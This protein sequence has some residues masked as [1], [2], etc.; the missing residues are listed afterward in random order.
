[1]LLLLACVDSTPKSETAPEETAT[2]PPPDNAVGSTDTG[3]EPDTWYPDA[4]QDGYGDRD[5]PIEACV[6]PEGAVTNANDCN[7]ADPEIHRWGQDLCDGSTDEDCDGTVDEDNTPGC[8]DRYADEDGDGVGGDDATCVCDPS[9]HPELADTGDCDDEDPLHASDC[10]SFLHDISEAT[11]TW[12]GSAELTRFYG[13]VIGDGTVTLMLEDALVPVSPGG[14]L[15]TGRTAWINGSNTAFRGLGD[16]DGD[17]VSELLAES[18]ISS[19]SW[20]DGCYCDVTEHHVTE[21]VIAAPMSGEQTTSAGTIFDLD[22]NVSAT[23]GFVGDIDGDGL[24][25]IGSVTDDGVGHTVFA[26]L[27]DEFERVYTGCPY[28]PAVA[29]GDLDGDGYNDVAVDGCIALGPFETFGY[30]ADNGV[31]W[32]IDLALAGDRDEDGYPELIDHDGLA[33]YELGYDVAGFDGTPIVSA[34]ASSTLSAVAVA[35]DEGPE[36]DLVVGQ[37]GRDADVGEEG[38]IFVYLDVPDGTLDLDG[39]DRRWWG[40][41]GE[42]LGQDVAALPDLDGDGSQDLAVTS[43]LGFY[44]IGAP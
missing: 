24:D 33:I 30:L 31:L 13:D 39:A 15:E 21:A 7:D 12:T 11:V 28:G 25:D 22:W 4:D 40:Q 10:T 23:A 8:V 6:A 36:N 41:P 44:V 42:F 29:A 16:W 38:A 19:T 27:E 43:S 18:W 2:T 1:M 34:D 26:S 3:C 20:S 32:G 17:G 9:A 5:N 14:D 35:L 37:A